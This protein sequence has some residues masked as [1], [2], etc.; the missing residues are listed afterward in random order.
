MQDTG[1]S[2]G[3]RIEDSWARTMGWGLTV[4]GWSGG[5]QRGKKVGQ[6]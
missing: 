6:L 1:A 2:Q 4:R 3:T 5:E